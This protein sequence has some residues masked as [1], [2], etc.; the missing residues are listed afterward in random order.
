LFFTKVWWYAGGPRINGW[1]ASSYWSR[2]RTQRYLGYVY[3]KKIKTG[4]VYCWIGF[5]W[6]L[7]VNKA[8]LMI[9]VS[10]A[11]DERIHSSLRRQAPPRWFHP[12][13][14]STHRNESIIA[15]ITGIEKL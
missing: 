13:W 1:R 3:E 10:G 9:E 8:A 12:D 4:T 2:S 5:I 6:D 15:S 7:K 14:Y 11:F